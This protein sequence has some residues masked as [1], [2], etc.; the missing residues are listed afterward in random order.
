MHKLLK[1]SFFLSAIILLSNACKD[2]EVVSP[3]SRDEFFIADFDGIEKN[4]TY[5]TNA[6]NISFEA[7][8]LETF[9]STGTL[10]S[11]TKGPGATLWQDANLATFLGGLDFETEERATIFFGQNV[12]A[13]REWSLD[14]LNNFNAIFQTSAYTYMDTDTSNAEI[15]GVEIR[16]TDDDLKVWSTRNGTQSGST[17]NVTKTEPFTTSDGDSQNK[18][19]GTFNCK[20]YDAAG[21]SVNVSNGTFFMTFQIL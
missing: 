11:Y 6:Y 13:E 9:D 14:S 21:N 19:D 10:V 5:S 12:F 18:V 2:D 17:F 20:L 15:P 1:L 3:G 4:L 7:Q 8:N 16:W